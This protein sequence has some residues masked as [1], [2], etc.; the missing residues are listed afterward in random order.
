MITN[1][2]NTSSLRCLCH[3]FLLL[4]CLTS[5]TNLLAIE[6]NYAEK[7]LSNVKLKIKKLQ[8]KQYTAKNK[9]HALQKELQLLDKNIAKTTLEIERAE[10]KISTLEKDI[11]ALEKE[12]APLQ[13]QFDE[14]S[15]QLSHS[16]VFSQQLSKADPLFLIANKKDPTLTKR[17]ITYLSYI[18]AYQVDL[19]KKVTDLEK[20]LKERKTA[21]KL[22]L[23]TLSVI[24]S[25]Q[26]Q[27][28]TLYTED[29]DLQK[30][31]IKA[32]SQQLKNRAR[33]L[34]VLKKNEQQLSKVLQNIEQKQLQKTDLEPF[35]RLKRRLPWPLKINNK[36]R[37]PNIYQLQKGNGIFIPTKEGRQIRAVR[38]GKVVFSDW[39]RGYGL[40]IILQHDNGFITLYA[41]NQAL[42]KHKG[43]TAF[44]G[45]KIATTG[46][47]GGQLADGLYF[48]IRRH[49]KPQPPQYWLQ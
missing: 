41:N 19:L 26:S 14:A 23:Q 39:L 17:L 12:Q 18:K 40:L 45:E 46:H 34:D 15:Q 16:L 6:T 31:I 20:N 32:I 10:N 1:M 11:T 7:K 33:H 47:S 8:H 5:S 37:K 44:T 49:G 9:Y 42:Y 38:T 3:S 25:E 43:E 21:I 22:K 28:L 4:W 30:D 24:Q 27:R 2:Q 36:G 35:Y 29:K 48:E 13:Q